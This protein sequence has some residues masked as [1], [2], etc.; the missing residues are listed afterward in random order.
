MTRISFNVSVPV[1][2]LQMT[3]AAPMVS[4]ACMRRT[5]LFAAAM[6]RTL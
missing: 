5:R 3:V 2:S 4:Q 6:R 1:L